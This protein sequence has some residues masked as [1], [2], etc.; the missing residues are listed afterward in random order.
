VVGVLPFAAETYLCLDLPAPVAERVLRI[1]RA[2][3]DAFR[4]ALPA[5]ITVA[6]SGGLGVISPGQ[7]PAT[8]FA[9]LDRVAATTSPI[10]ARFGPVHR[11]PN[12]DVFI[13]SLADETP[14]RL[15]QQRL[16]SSGI[17]FEPS[18]FPFTPHC[19]LR[20]R[21]PVSAAEECSLFAVR[22]AESFVIQTLTAYALDGLPMTQLHA[23]RFTGSS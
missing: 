9:A 13:L 14:F 2:H 12:T 8:V 18:P 10:M 6:G 16:A 19:T 20:S 23:A 7:D 21:S 15:L 4:A 1:R 3:Q 11:F 17:R 22:I 5:E